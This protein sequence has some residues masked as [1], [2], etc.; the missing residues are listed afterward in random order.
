MLVWLSV[1][2]EVQTCMWPSWY[3]CHSLSLASV[4]SRLVFTFLVLVHPGSC[5]KGPLNVCVCVCVCYRSDSR[6]LEEERCLTSVS[7]LRPL[8]SPLCWLWVGLTCRCRTD[9]FPLEDEE[10]GGVA[11]PGSVVWLGELAAAATRVC[12][13]N[14]PCYSNDSKWSVNSDEGPFSRSLNKLLRPRTCHPHSGRVHSEAFTATSCPC[15]QVCRPVLLHRLL[16]TLSD[17]IQ[18]GEPQKLPLPLGV[19]APTLYI[20]PSAN[21]SPQPKTASR[22]TQPFL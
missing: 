9:C 16:L 21:Q 8:P 15:G 7:D 2:S 14:G 1:W 18:W 13:C 10:L 5:R 6:P 19:R 17:G 11:E 20:V 3:H 4:K 22:S 12:W